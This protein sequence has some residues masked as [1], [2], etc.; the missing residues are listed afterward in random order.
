[1]NNNKKISIIKS[2]LVSLSIL[3]SGFFYIA[4]WLEGWN[5]MF[6]FLAVGIIGFLLIGFFIFGLVTL[7]KTKKKE[8]YFPL[9]IALIAIMIVVFRPIEFIIE[10]LKSPVVLHGY[11]EH[12]VTEV[13]IRLRQD[14]T[15][16]YNAGTFLSNKVYNGKYSLISDTI[17]LEFNNAPDYINDRLLLTDFSLIE[18]GDTASHRHDFKIIYN[19]LIK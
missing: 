8:L 10:E 1:M 11:C 19:E 5:G 14:G 7:F 17:K 18:I 15:F 9:T 6:L 12:T 16:E 4:Y 13:S 2:G 3:F